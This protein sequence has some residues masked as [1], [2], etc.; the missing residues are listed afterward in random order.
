MDDDGTTGRHR[1]LID[2]DLCGA[3]GVSRPFDGV[4]LNPVV[5]GPPFDPNP[6]KLETGG[7]GFRMCL[8]CSAVVDASVGHECEVPA[9]TLASRVLTERVRAEFA[10]SVLCALAFDVQRLV[11]DVRHGE[12]CDP[13]HP[14][15]DCIFCVAKK[16][17]LD[18]ARGE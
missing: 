2:D 7:Y 11:I 13:G 8:T 17:K 18:A 16:G 1:E 6:P 14:D 4:G 15:R 10:E 12:G 3:S 9:I 5:L